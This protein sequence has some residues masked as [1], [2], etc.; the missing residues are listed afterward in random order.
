MRLYT[1][2]NFYLSSIQQGVQSLHVTSELFVKYDQPTSRLYQRS[3]LFEWARLHK[4][5][6]ILNGGAHDD[7][8]AI[9][10]ELEALGS[11]LGYPTACFSEDQYSLG[12][13]LTACGIVIPDTIYGA[14]PNDKLTPDQVKQIQSWLGGPAYYSFREDGTYTG[15]AHLQ[16]STAGRLIELV[17]SKGLAR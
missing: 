17:K 8:V 9:N 4:T 7:I 15:T 16:D 3:V 6:I 11:Q 2:V 13:I 10:G 5:V 1:F 12:G 14:V